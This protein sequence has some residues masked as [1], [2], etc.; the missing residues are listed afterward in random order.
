[1]RILLGVDYTTTKGK[2]AR[3]KRSTQYK[4]QIQATLNT[5]N[6][7]KKNKQIKTTKHF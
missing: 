4:V 1:L 7:S 3:R 5:N 2:H 6:K